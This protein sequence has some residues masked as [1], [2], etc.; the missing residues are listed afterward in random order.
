MFMKRLKSIAAGILAAAAFFLIPGTNVAASEFK[1]PHIVG[2][3]EVIY[4]DGKDQITVKGGEILSVSYFSGNPAVAAVN[5]KGVVKPKNKGTAVIG[6]KTAYRQ[7][8]GKKKTKTLQYTVKVLGKSTEYFTYNKAN[9]ITGLKPK[10]AKLKSLSIPGYNGNG[11]KKITQMYGTAL[12]GNKN[13]RY[14]SVSDNLET[15]VPHVEDE[16]IYSLTDCP[17]LK[18]IR[19]GKNF[20]GLGYLR[21]C[22]SV[23]SVSVDERNASYQ[24]VDGVYF[25]KNGKNLIYYPAGKKDASYTIPDGTKYICGYAFYEAAG[26]DQ[27]YLPDSVTLIAEAAFQNSSLRQVH[28]PKTA[29]IQMGEGWSFSGCTNLESVTIPEGVTQLTDYLFEG[30]TSLKTVVLPSTLEQLSGSVF[31]GCGSLTDISFAGENEAY[32]ITDGVVYTQD[33]KKLA[34]YPAG[35]PRKSYTIS[36]GTETIGEFAFHA[37]SFLQEVLIPDSAVAIER[38]AFAQTGLRSVSVPSSVKA[39]ETG[40]FHDCQK[41][42]EVTLTDGLERLDTAFG[43]CTALKSIRIPA[44]VTSIAYAPF[45][46]CRELKEILADETSRYFRTD[47]G[48]LYS[49]NGKK[50]LCYPPGKT[51]VSFTL[52][53]TVEEIAPMAFSCLAYTKHLDVPGV[54]IIGGYAF[55]RSKNLETVVLPKK[56]ADLSVGLFA[57]CTGLVSVALPDGITTIPY[58]T[59]ENCSK[60]ETVVIGKNVTK[61]EGYAFTRCGSLK[62]LVVK[63]KKLTKN[64]LN[65]SSFVESGDRRGVKLS[66]SVTGSE[67]IKYKEYFKKAGLTCPL[68]IK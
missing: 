51:D 12:T 25:S 47:G 9:Q 55:E 53:E 44:S 4:L 5:Q 65:S 58:Q 10:A 48:I 6:A 64:S 68:M 54:K 21:K 42:S 66:L 60:L 31:S 52:P 50:L 16:Y 22:P 34:V 37:A 7:K 59:F 19:L 45:E 8:N 15:F 62:K 13:L 1:T 49:K 35:N 20:G 2:Q 67:K 32:Q 24:A 39:L 43:G 14:L 28:F 23:E 27:V 41:L 40:V 30:C 46:G 11:K 3:E 17:N 56:M 18:S 36:A 61:I 63:T 26:L 33:G 29:S 38:Y 57:G